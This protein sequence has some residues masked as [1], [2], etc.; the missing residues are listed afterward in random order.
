MAHFESG[1]SAQLNIPSLLIIDKNDEL[2]S[3]SGLADFIKR[4][5]LSDWQLD[6]VRKDQSASTWFHHLLLDTQTLGTSS[7]NVMMT[8]I[9]NFLLPEQ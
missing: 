7:W 3:P 1:S 8:R 5:Q 9:E 4:H 6:Y 2:V